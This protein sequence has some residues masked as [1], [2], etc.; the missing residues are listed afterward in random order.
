MAAAPR[1]GLDRRPGVLSLSERCLDLPARDAYDACIGRL[2]GVRAVQYT[3]RNIPL[4]LDEALRQRAQAE[5]KSLNEVAIEAMS[6]AVG[7][8]GAPLRRRDLSD[9]RGTWV[10]DPAVEEAL[11]DQRRIDPEIWR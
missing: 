8:S 9:I 7:L 5:R 6:E 1:G 4:K 11:A 3:L 10:E 2:L